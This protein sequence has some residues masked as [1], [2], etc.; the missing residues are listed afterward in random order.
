MQTTLKLKNHAEIINPPLEVREDIEKSLTIP[1][2]AYA[3]AVR[4]GRWTGNIPEHIRLFKDTP[5]DGI[6]VPRGWA[7]RAFE[8]LRRH[9]VDFTMDDQRRLLIPLSI[10]FSGALRIYQQAA[11]N[12]VLHRDFG[13]LEAATGSG[14]T[15]MALSATAR[16]Q[17]PTI[18]LVHTKE[19]LAQWAER[20]RSFL[21]IEPG[22][23]GSGRYDIKEVTVA[24]VQTAR[25]HLDDLPSHFG[26]IIVDECHRTPSSTFQEVVSA[27]DAKYMLGLSATA[28][29]RDGLTRL[30]YLAL[31]DRVHRVDPGVLQANGAVLTPKIII[32]ETA[33]Q[34]EYNE[35]Y[36]AMIAE[37]VADPAR[38]RLIARDVCTNTK[39]DTALVV[40]DRVEH[41]HILARMVDF[42][43]T[44]IL[45]G[46]SPKAER[47]RIVEDVNA[48]RV[49]VLFATVQLLGEG[50]D[51]PGL[52]DL[53]LATPI[54][55]KGR[56][57]QTAGRILRPAPG[58]VA[59]IYDYVDI[60]QPVLAAQARTRARALAEVAGIT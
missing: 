11:V 22:L 54:K 50:F 56:V 51:C 41:L 33:F 17:Q 6:R 20:V 42:D 10:S 30:I 52:T 59:R 27:F 15:V 14:K 35:D 47:G 32:R 2:P 44:E 55:Y 40:S 38:N 49:R 18:I 4:H 12:D 19:L 46:N 37:L 29:R 57:I 28:Y 23:V 48:G 8:K 58:K 36:Q 34:Y 1:N 31:G 3:E 43:G 16:R 45:T 7:R 5:D 21:G 60:E 9:N 53:Y 25:K 39:S 24:M 13:V 26:Q